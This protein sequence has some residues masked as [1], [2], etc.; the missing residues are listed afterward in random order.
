MRRL[1]NTT[2]ALLLS[3]AGLFAQ[4]YKV[5]EEIAAIPE[6]TSSY[7]WVHDFSHGPLTPSPEGYTPFY[8]DM[9]A[10]HGA[11]LA[12][13]DIY[14]RL[15][16][17]L[18]RADSAGVLTD[19]GRDFKARLETI[20]PPT[21]HII[22]KLTRKGWEQHRIIASN[23][24]QDFPEVFDAGARVRAIS[25]PIY[26]CVMSMASCCMEIAR[27]YPELDIYEDMNWTRMPEVNPTNRRNPFPVPYRKMEKPFKDRY[28]TLDL[29]ALASRLISNPESFLD[30]DYGVYKF[31]D[32]I[33]TLSSGIASTDFEVSFDDF[34]VSQDEKTLYWMMQN[35]GSF[36]YAYGSQFRYYSVVKSLIDNGDAGIAAGAP[37]VD[38][39]FGH[40]NIVEP[41]LI[42]LNINGSGH[43]A[44][45]VEEQLYWYQNYNICM[46]AHIVTVL[47]RGPEGSPILFKI[48]L[49]DEET[50]LPDLTP[51]DGPY[52][53]WDDFRSFVLDTVGARAAATIQ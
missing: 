24:M 19:Y 52:Y 20:I 9:Y 14:V 53:R 45:K 51:V 15:D 44:D 21:R 7:D 5:F 43:I 34:F 1:L 40:D 48:L 6:R 17:L 39:R 10:R 13:D 35:A 3:A 27:K 23:M 18:A 26:R 37:S 25:S 30:E 46:A 50:T 2:I 32:D 22:G 4:N 41:I 8:I 29:T 36:N 38:L 16:T 33:Y 12:W 28:E 11:R 31:V 49:N 42:M 47:Y